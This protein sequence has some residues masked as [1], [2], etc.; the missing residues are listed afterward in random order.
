M[1]DYTILRRARHVITECDR[2]KKSIECLKN[3]DI[4]EFGKLLNLS[5]YS[6][7]DDYEVTGIELDTLSDL[8]RKSD[9][10]IGAR[11][12]GAGF[13]GC[14]ICLVEKGK[15]DNLK[16][17]CTRE[18]KKIIGYEPT[19][20]DITI[21]DGVKIEKKDS[22]TEIK[23][24]IE[25]L[26]CYAEKYLDLPK[27]DEI[28][29]RNLLLTQFKINEP[30]TE[31]INKKIVEE[32]LVPDRLIDTIKSVSIKNGLC[33]V[34]DENK[35]ANYILGLLTPT[36]S[37]VNE[38]FYKLNKEK[39]NKATD[40]FYN[41]CIKNNYIQKTAIDKN[42]KWDC[43]VQNKK[44]EITINM[45]KPEKNNKD[46]AKL[47][48]QKNVVSNYPKCPLCS[49]NEGFYGSQKI[50]PR[51]NIRTIS[52]KLNNEN[53]FMQYSP[54]SYYTEH[55]ICINREHTPMDI[56][57]GTL[58]KMFDFTRVFPH[59][60]IGSN[61]SLPYI[62]GSI[63]NHEHFQGG[64]HKL[65]MFFTDYKEIIPQDRYK[66]T[67]IGILD[68]FNSV[69]MLS[70]KNKKE[71]IEIGSKIILAWK[72]YENKELKI[73]NKSDGVLHN[74]LSPILR[75][76]ENGEYNLYLILRNNILTEDYPEGYFH[77]HPEYHNIKKEGIG[78]IEAMGTF[79]LPARLKRQ[80][81]LIAKI[82]CKE[83]EY[84]PAELSKADNDLY[85]HRDMI[86][87]LVENYQC[88]T[89][90]K[91]IRIV[92]ERVNNVCANILDN[93]SVFKDNIDIFRQFITDTINK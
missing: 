20:Y 39:C 52:L 23:I 73:I 41:L 76:N 13:G 12:T 66:K 71:L 90:K 84:N 11:M 18:Y 38:K 75:I 44:L 42:I 93:T 72:E 88:D 46:I 24:L 3:G 58:E 29:F 48:N 81:D 63:L 89:Y 68:W 26:L 10:C 30:Y 8:M 21:E 1:T 16:E 17:I 64:K 51:T 14:C 4:I 32:L 50:A 2:V 40:Y 59:Y 27:C 60:F 43:R 5:H 92:K 91:A 70:G 65:P 37:Q 56:Y 57:P 25:E 55:C 15:E 45:S 34:G 9:G 19:F 31:K 49:D 82:L 53:W 36:P 35:F 85:V 6:L 54:Y 78:L 80:L 61:A 62:G 79:I 67:K 7:R 86:K 74:S 83:I 33:Q 22:T 69:I 87:F 77:A 47:A 28:Y